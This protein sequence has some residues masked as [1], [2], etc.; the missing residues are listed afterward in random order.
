MSSHLWVSHL[1]SS[2][3]HIPIFHL[4]ICA[5]HP[6]IFT[7]LHLQHIYFCA[8]FQDFIF[9]R[10]NFFCPPSIASSRGA[11]AN[12][13]QPWA[14]AT[15]M[16][17]TNGGQPIMIVCRNQSRC[18][19]VDHTFPFIVSHIPKCQYLAYA[20]KFALPS[21]PR[22]SDNF[23]PRGSLCS[24]RRAYMLRGKGATYSPNRHQYCVKRCPD[25]VFKLKCWIMQDNLSFQTWR[26][27][28]HQSA[29]SKTPGGSTIKFSAVSGKQHWFCAS[30]ECTL[31]DADNQIQPLGSRRDRNNM[32]ARQHLLCCRLKLCY[33]QRTD[34]RQRLA[35]D[36]SY[37]PLFLPV[38]LHSTNKS[39][40]CVRPY[41]L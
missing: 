37:P 2:F 7:S 23:L 40:T 25:P 28:C 21:V 19:A 13:W 41:F 26:T 5:C 30:R 8:H 18:S 15:K 27:S 4:H 20:G 17:H 32:A 9:P 16:K 39:A 24:I 22:E 38:A 11:P 10:S 1:Q 3:S 34:V 36:D 12:Q 33:W 6:L 35:V 29:Q 14:Q 31:L